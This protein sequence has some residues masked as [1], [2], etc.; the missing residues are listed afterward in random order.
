VE[1]SVPVAQK[2]QSQGVAGVTDEIS[3]QVGDLKG[4][5]LGKI[6]EY[7]I[8]TVL[9]AGITWIISLLNPASAF[10]RACK[11]IIDIVTF[12]VTQGA[13]IIEFV[14]AVLDAVIAIAKGG[15]GGVPALIENALAR[16]IPVLIGALAAILGIGGIANKI[17]SFFQTL[18]KPVRKAVDWITD[19]IVTIGKKL[20]T[21]LKS[22][23]RSGNNGKDQ[24]SATEK[25]A[26]VKAAIRDAE[27]IMDKPGSSRQKVQS[28]LSRIKSR[29]KLNEIKIVD[30][31]T[32]FHVYASINPDDTSKEKDK[33]EIVEIAREDISTTKPELS[34][35]SWDVNLKAKVPGGSVLWGM[36]SVNLDKNG[37]PD[38][39]GPSMYI[40]KKDITIDTDEI[41]FKG[42][43]ITL[44]TKFSITDVALELVNAA[45][46]STF[47]SDPPVL[48]GSLAEKNKAN[49][50]RE[51]HKAQLAN[52]G[53]DSDTWAQTAIRNISFG[54]SR[55]ALGYDL[56]ELKM[57][58]LTLVDLGEE[59]GFQR[60]PDTI[61]IVARK[62]KP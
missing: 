9:I 40:S 23:N 43:K 55:I 14:N 4:N 26:A 24:R 62:S 19:K 46:R 25:T 31:Q 36:A 16:S 50:Q 18:T 52:P 41:E 20:W 15:T 1:A 32:S 7:L 59:F 13:Q 47:G 56:F 61:N 35:S 58:Q 51:W 17:R 54:R 38:T 45:Y 10:I 48:N 57:G 44:K 22:K 12:I 3:Q 27:A 42:R 37:K 5:L 8:P 6:S 2:L 34:K 60:V 28:A 39:E 21:K 11:M 49:F 29:H 30:T 33:S 53:A